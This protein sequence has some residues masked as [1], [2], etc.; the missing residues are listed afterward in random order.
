MPSRRMYR[1]ALSLAFV[2]VSVWPAPPAGPGTPQASGRGDRSLSSV[3]GFYHWGGAPVDDL[4]GGLARLHELH[5]RIARVAI[6][7]RMDVDYHRAG[8]CIPGF[9]LPA[10][11][12]DPDLRLFLDDDQLD[13]LIVTAYDG[14]GFGDCA[15]PKYLVPTFYSRENIARM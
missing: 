8:R 6:S 13:T 3:M 1:T 14:T 15:T 11:L 10:T 5:A 9:S 12:D 7:A 2:C 4:R